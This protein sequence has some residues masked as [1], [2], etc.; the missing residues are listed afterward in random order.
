MKKVFIIINKYNN[1]YLRIHSDRNSKLIRTSF[2]LTKFN[3]SINIQKTIVNILR[4]YTNIF[5]K[6]FS[7]YVFKNKF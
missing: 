7:K 2:N 3:N 1:H 4:Y 5:L 6:S